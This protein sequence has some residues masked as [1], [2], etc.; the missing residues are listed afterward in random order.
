MNKPGNITV[1]DCVNSQ[2]LLTYKAEEKEQLYKLIEKNIAKIFYA[3]GHDM[4]K[5]RIEILTELLIESRK[6]ETP[7]TILSFL[8][9]CAKGELGKFY[10][11]PGIDQLQE[12]F[13]TFLE[14]SIIPERERQKGKPEKYDNQREQ[15]QTIQEFGKNYIKFIG[16]SK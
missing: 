10:G 11:K 8:H 3:L 15:P 5:N 7:E 12:K 1:S 2:A 16:E 6:Y 4:E 9:K 13:A 14:S